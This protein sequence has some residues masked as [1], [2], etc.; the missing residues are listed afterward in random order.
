MK[1]KNVK[2]GAI[3]EFGE[4][5]YTLDHIY[6]NAA[7]NNYVFAFC[8]KQGKGIKVRKI[9]A[10]DMDKDMSEL[11]LDFKVIVPSKKYMSML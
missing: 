10:N 8:N 5:K 3:V 1:M 7:E 4:C 9:W 6:F 2:Y 11:Y